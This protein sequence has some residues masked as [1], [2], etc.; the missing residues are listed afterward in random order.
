M[1]WKVEMAPNF[2]WT[3]CACMPWKPPS[4]FLATPLKIFVHV[5]FI[6]C[7]LANS[8]GDQKMWTTYSIIDQLNLVGVVRPN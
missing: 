3:L 7:S 1:T 5:L 2:S 8:V 6:M 4:Q